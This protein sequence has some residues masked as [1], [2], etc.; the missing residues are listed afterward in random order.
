MKK[1]TALLLCACVLASLLA[2]CS[3]SSGYRDDVAVN[4][5]AA[6]VESKISSTDLLS[7]DDSYVSG[8]MK[9]DAGSYKEY[10]IK[11]AST[12]TAIDEFGIFRCS[13]ESSAKTVEA[14]AKAYIQTRT[15]SWMPEYRPQE[16]PK[17]QNAEVK[18]CGNYVIY[19]ILSDAD[20][21]AAF[22]AFE[23]ALKK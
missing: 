7:P 12:G 19:A 15:D 23:S 21:E 17:M 13:D 14:A 11:I 3:S 2:A 22:S 6:A 4:D 20:R 8:T 16:F 1:T 9:I 18:V 10:V 5:L